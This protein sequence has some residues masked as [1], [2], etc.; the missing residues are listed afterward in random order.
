MDTI[1][2]KQ[3]LNLDIPKLTSEFN[4]QELADFVNF[5]DIPKRQHN[6]L[7][8]LNKL[9]GICNILSYLVPGRYEYLQAITKYLTEHKLDNDLQNKLISTQAGDRSG[10][11]S[12]Y[13]VF[14]AL[15]KI[16]H[17][18]NSINIFELLI[19][20]TYLIKDIAPDITPNP[21]T[22]TNLISISRSIRKQSSRS[23]PLFAKL[24]PIEIHELANINTSLNSYSKAIG[25]NKSPELISLISYFLNFRKE[26]QPDAIQ[27]EK[28]VEPVDEVENTPI[29]RRLS[30]KNLIRKIKAGSSKRPSSPIIISIPPTNI[31]EDVDRSGIINED[32]IEDDS[33]VVENEKIDGEDKS[34][35]GNR[36]AAK[37]CQ[38][39]GIMQAQFSRYR[40]ERLSTTE[41][42][43]IIALSQSS[44]EIGA[45]A[46][47]LTLCFGSEPLVWGTFK[48][49][50]QSDNSSF[51]DLDN[52]LWG[53]PI[54]NHE[55]A[56]KPNNEQIA[57][58]Y[59]VENIIK[60][61]L[62]LIICKRLS[63][64]IMPET[65]IV[66]DLFSKTPTE[67]QK[68]LENWLLSIGCRNRQLTPSKLREE[69]YSTIMDQTMDEVAAHMIS[70]Q[71]TF[72]LP[73]QAFYTAFHTKQ[74][75][76][77]YNRAL[78]EIFNCS[79]DM[80]L[81]IN[82]LHGSR[83]QAHEAILVNLI[84]SLK[85]EV[86]NISNNN[87]I[88]YHNNFVLYTYQMLS[89]ATG[90][91]LVL[92]PF[93][94]KTD[95]IE[96][97]KS[98]IIYDKETDINHTG[99]ATILGHIAWEQFLN[100]KEHL[101]KLSNKVYAED[102]L[103]R[104]KIIGCLNGKQTLPFLFLLKREN[105]NIKVINISENSLKEVMPNWP[106]PLNTHR[107]LLATKLR[108]IGA[109]SEMIEYQLGHFQNGTQALGLA[110]TL[111]LSDIEEHL[112]PYIDK[113]LTQLK[114]EPVI[115]KIRASDPKTKTQETKR[116]QLG[117][118]KRLEK[119]DKRKKLENSI[120]KTELNNLT[121]KLSE[122]SSFPKELFEEQG[123][124][125]I[126]S[127]IESL[128]EHKKM[129]NRGRALYLFNKTLIRFLNKNKMKL[130]INFSF[131]KVT[132]DP[133]P[134]SS[135][136]G[137]DY[138]QFLEIKEAFIKAT[139]QLL[140][141]K[142]DINYL[143]AFSLIQ[144]IILG[145]MHNP[146]WI[147]NY[148]LS[149]QEGLIIKPS[150]VGI[151][152]R[153]T[154]KNEGVF[155]YEPSDA[156]KLLFIAKKSDFEFQK[157]KIKQQKIEKLC[158]DILKNIH[159]PNR[160]KSLSINKLLSLAKS[161]DA[162][163]L[164]G[165]LRAICTGEIKTFSIEPNRDE[166]IR[167]GYPLELLD[168]YSPR[169]KRALNFDM[170]SWA[171]ISPN[172]KETK[173]V[174]KI[175]RNLFKNQELT[176][177][178]GSQKK[179]FLTHLDDLLSSKTDIYPIYMHLLEWGK[180]ILSNPNNKRTRATYVNK[181]IHS[182]SNGLIEAFQETDITKLKPDDFIKAYNQVI[183]FYPSF[184]D[185]TE[186]II[187]HVQ[188]LQ[189]FHKYLVESYGVA[190]IDFLDLDLPE[191]IS[192]YMV[193]A[194]YI[195]IEEYRIILK[196]LKEDPVANE[197]QRSYQSVAFC[198][199]FNFGLRS[200]ELFSLSIK[201]IQL[202]FEGS[203]TGSITIQP[204]RYETLKTLASKR[205]LPISIWQ[206][207]EEVALIKDFLQIR[208]EQ[209]AK[210]NSPLF[211]W[212]GN[213]FVSNIDN[214]KNRIVYAMRY[215]TGDTSLNM[216]HLRHSFATW[217]TS[218]LIDLPT[219]SFSKNEVKFEALKSHFNFK[220]SRRGLF[221]VAEFMG[222]SH[223]LTTI[224]NYIHGFDD[225]L[226]EYSTSNE[227]YSHNYQFI[228]TLSTVKPATLRKWKSRFKN[229]ENLIRFT[230]ARLLHSE[231][232]DESEV[233]FY[234]TSLPESAYKQP[235]LDLSLQQLQWLVIRFPDLGDIENT[236]QALFCQPEEIGALLE[237]FKSIGEISGYIPQPLKKMFSDK[238]NVIED[239]KIS[240]HFQS[241][242]RQDINHKWIKSLEDSIKDDSQTKDLINQML[243][244]W[245]RYIFPKET[246]WKLEKLEQLE[247]FV[248]ALHHTSIPYSSMELIGNNNYPNSGV[249]KKLKKKN[250]KNHEKS[251]LPRKYFTINP[252]KNTLDL[253]VLNKRATST[254]NTMNFFLFLAAS[255]M[256]AKKKI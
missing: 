65:K 240:N 216:H 96:A 131:N 183:Q 163:Q 251:K 36:V 137:K 119:R 230:A 98:A 226:S 53:H 117:F 23:H 3:Y 179:R 81:N 148:C 105:R 213:K 83:L 71:P 221:Q 72:Q 243:S 22:K 128:L 74:L 17:T 141:K 198:I 84:E 184:Q 192:S 196:A 203:S 101:R 125:L 38:Q 162:I 10:L 124:K 111:S 176:K 100:Y 199:G 114:F 86:S 89:H 134:F 217:I 200:S 190:D 40:W 16:P 118:E 139:P 46:A 177:Q 246:Y 157:T 13:P 27:S 41:K 197:S 144:E 204:N 244:L 234:A 219:S 241:I 48:T 178:D 66:S 229:E 108:E 123:E 182:N 238:F 76:Q 247:I 50:S 12:S 186:Q 75:S 174:Q 9:S 7:G 236:A 170:H 132:K 211:G 82:E 223:P 189:S 167:T 14:N 54:E 45:T 245:K 68:E 149:L 254:V 256:M 2:N 160:P 97:V 21:A 120:I 212:Y 78:N 51:I 250:R 227:L 126:E 28:K 94:Q 79:I 232:F 121:A 113:L 60:L 70:A 110:S 88:N 15:Q 166:A 95:F 39:K 143:V 145:R 206:E 57:L 252:E 187:T 19:A 130:K 210:E 58:V 91:R 201:D 154:E 165:V 115:S 209:G 26:N 233:Q 8:Q 136:T 175:T 93:A 44:N 194:N 33:S 225:W 138:H 172:Y 255:L 24:Q 35:A 29:N 112:T 4:H 67:L 69:L 202:V 80:N 43:L 249:L 215:I 103:L 161:V 248:K 30:P 237:S 207:E 152:L 116:I 164:P 158:E 104:S 193:S 231:D 151:Y 122:I 49:N 32:S 168:D 140:H 107:H 47:I 150:G 1:D 85:N 171:S 147:R 129:V 106:L 99:R 155:K 253:K 77:I 42:T 169:K 102:T 127:S 220:S 222:H 153:F 18:Q 87:F 235:V 228:A 52:Q 31:Q 109:S 20:L 61:P 180:Y 5:F 239:E 173:K 188:D 59:Q 142:N 224:T 73:T 37:A 34:T 6:L 185:A 214:I 195:N 90:H 11:T 156:G 242:P 133:S 64:K 63:R 191:S 62:P 181:A 208:L 135:R 146:S 92:D 159:F 218:A 25:E 55:N 56:W 205:N